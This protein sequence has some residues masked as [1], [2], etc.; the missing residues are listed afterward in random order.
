[1]SDGAGLEQRTVIAKQVIVVRKDIKM[2]A[3][4]V[5]A[6]VSHASMA[7]ILHLF[8]K[9]VDSD[10]TETRCFI[11]NPANPVDRAVQ[12]WLDGSFTKVVVGIDTGDELSQLYDNASALGIP[13]SK[14][15]DSGRTVFNGIPTL[16]C[17]AFGP[18]Y[19][20]VLHGLTGHLKLLGKI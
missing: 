1:M 10:G 17:C 3:G 4:K 19:S 11:L 20:D 14:I 2:P 18:A 15:V 12:E 13:C 8:H 6:Q 5:L 16:T 7:P 9:T